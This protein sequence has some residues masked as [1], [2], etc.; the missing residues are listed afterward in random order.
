MPSI[1]TIVGL[2]TIIGALAAALKML[3]DTAQF[4]KGMRDDLKGLREDMREA[5]D[6][7]KEHIAEDDRQFASIHADVGIL[8]VNSAR[9]M[10]SLGLE[11]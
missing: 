3:W 2:V 6:A 1:S 4:F 5:S 9:V 11:N 8:K 10:T 7:H